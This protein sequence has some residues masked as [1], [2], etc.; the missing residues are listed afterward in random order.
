MA[1]FFHN[2]S[3]PN[4]VRSVPSRGSSGLVVSR[5]RKPRRIVV[6]GNS[7]ATGAVS[8]CAAGLAGAGR[9]SPAFLVK[10]QTIFRIK[11]HTALTLPV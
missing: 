10:S 6:V 5:C 11:T 2:I 7:P 3:Y 1:S 9:A 8:I 4:D